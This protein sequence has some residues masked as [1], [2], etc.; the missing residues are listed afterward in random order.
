MQDEGFDCPDKIRLGMAIR[1][2]VRGIP[3]GQTAL[4]L[5][6]GVCRFGMGAQVIPESEVPS[7]FVT[8]LQHNVE[9]VR[10]RIALAQ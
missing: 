10:A 1:L 8:T 2:T 4:E 7:M 3:L 6:I 9:V 5:R